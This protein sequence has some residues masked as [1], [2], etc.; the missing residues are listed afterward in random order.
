MVYSEFTKIGNKE[1]GIRFD[2]F[3]NS[4]VVWVRK[5]GKSQDMTPA[6]GNGVD[7]QNRLADELLK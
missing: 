4:Y 1:G 6:Y 5:G 7:A 3:A 2:A